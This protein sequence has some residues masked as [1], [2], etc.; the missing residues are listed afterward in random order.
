M[1]EQGSAPLTCC[2]AFYHVL[3]EV[4]LLGQQVL[5]DVEEWDGWKYGTWVSR[6]VTHGPKAAHVFAIGNRQT[7]LIQWH[8]QRSWC[9]DDLQAWHAN[10]L[11]CGI[12]H[13]IAHRLDGPDAVSAEQAGL[14]ARHGELACE[15]PALVHTGKRTVVLAVADEVQGNDVSS[16]AIEFAEGHLAFAG[17]DAAS[18]VAFGSGEGAHNGAVANRTCRQQ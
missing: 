14:A 12:I 10:I 3:E 13:V 11:L 1:Q 7:R 16:E 17:A 8:V 5:L 2:N 9:I 18:T 15:V 4:K 6:A